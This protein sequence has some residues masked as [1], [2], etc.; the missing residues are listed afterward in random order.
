MPGRSTKDICDPHFEG[1]FLPKP[2]V[3]TPGFFWSGPVENIP[4]VRD[5]RTTWLRSVFRA[6]LLRCRR[7]EKRDDGFRLLAPAVYEVGFGF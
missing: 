5:V 2:G 4:L 3:V 7:L 1:C 6:V